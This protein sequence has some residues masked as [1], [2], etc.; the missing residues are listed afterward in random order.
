[1][2]KNKS[3]FVLTSG[4]SSVYPAFVSQR[5]K[6]K[7]DAEAIQRDMALKGWMAT[8]LARAAGLSKMTISKFLKGELQTAKSAGKIARALGY[9]IRRYFAG[10]ET[11]A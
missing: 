8:D 5:H 3:T 4:F 1:M 2:V 6:P 7:F 9:S 10:V 11:A